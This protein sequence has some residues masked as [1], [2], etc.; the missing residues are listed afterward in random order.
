MYSVVKKIKLVQQYALSYYHFLNSVS[1]KAT[2]K[3]FFSFSFL[4]EIVLSILD[5]LS[6]KKIILIDK[7]LHNTI[8]S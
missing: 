8:F 4:D 1:V 2:K 5:Y 7:S 3:V 6:P